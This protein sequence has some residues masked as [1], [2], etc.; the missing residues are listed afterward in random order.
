MQALGLPLARE[1]LAIPLRAGLIVDTGRNSVTLSREGSNASAGEPGH[2]PRR[3][4][5]VWLRVPEVSVLVAVMAISFAIWGFAELTEEVVEGDTSSFDESLLLA[6]RTETDHTDPLGPGWMEEMGRDFTAL[7]GIGVLTVTTV[8]VIGYL[9][10]EG[11]RRLALV[12]VFASLGSLALSSGLK[13]SIDRPRPDLVPHGSI[14]Y[15]QSFPSG[16]SMQSAATYLTLSALLSGVQRRRANKVYLISIAVFVTLLVGVS[17][18]YLGVHWPTDVLAG[19]TAG[20]AWALACWLLARWLLH[21]GQ[22]ESEE[23]VAD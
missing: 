7:G 11:K 16:H 13:H 19:W 9:L 18:V 1:P 21:H 5:P 15:T 17:R 3:G 23:E 2:N 6:L 20:A 4:R 8:G 14:V 10:L 22:T 12:V